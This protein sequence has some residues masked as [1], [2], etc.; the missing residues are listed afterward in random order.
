M[1]EEINTNSL[2]NKY[3]RYVAGGV[4]EHANGFI[5]WWE[6]SEFQQSS[7]DIV[8]AIENIY[9]GRLDLIASV[10]YNEPRW[11]WIIAQYNNIL[12]PFSEIVAGR[13]LL[14][15]TAER[16]A[17]MISKRQGGVASEKQPVN[18]ISPVII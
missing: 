15:P 10:F 2:Y 7:S 5:E 12:D 18:T 8:Y 16:L 3:S 4:T 17:F 14:I 9:E 6:R 13:I 11:W 1:S